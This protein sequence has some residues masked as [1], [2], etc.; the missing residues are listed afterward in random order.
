MELNN[1]VITIFT[2][3]EAPVAICRTYA[4]PFDWCPHRAHVCV[5]NYSLYD[6]N[7][8]APVAMKNGMQYI[9]LFYIWFQG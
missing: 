2:G 7:D 6:I 9:I 3:E 8:M 1:T 5:P 4:T